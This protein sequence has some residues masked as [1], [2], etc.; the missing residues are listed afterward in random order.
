MYM[1]ACVHVRAPARRVGLEL[2]ERTVRA[3]SEEFESE[4]ECAVQVK[5]AKYKW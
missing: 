4:K 3:A 1:V 2:F 5:R